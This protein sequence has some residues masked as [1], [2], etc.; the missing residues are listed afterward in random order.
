M[1]LIKAKSKAI[2]SQN[3]R[4]MQDAGHGYGITGPVTATMTTAYDDTTSHGV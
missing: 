3:I 4:E 2:I 1:P